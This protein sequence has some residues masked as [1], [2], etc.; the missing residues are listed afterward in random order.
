MPPALWL[1]LNLP[2]LALDALGPW[3][4]GV[5][6]PALVWQ[7]DAGGRTRTVLI[8]NAAAQAL[9]VQAGQRLGS[10]QALAP[11][12]L[13][14][15]R[16]PAREAALLERLAL[17]LGSLS[18][19][20]VIEPPDL[21]LD[22]HASLRLFG[23]LRPLLRRADRLVRA[24]AVQPRWSLASTPLAARLLAHAPPAQR[25]RR[26]VQLRSTRRRVLAL[27]LA[28]L[29]AWGLPCGATG[30][31]RR[32]ADGP[33]DAA[34]VAARRAAAAHI[35]TL[36]MLHALGARCLADLQ[37]LPRAG[38]RRRGAQDWVDAL[39]RALGDQP[40]PRRCHDPPEAFALALELPW[41][42]DA[43]P[44]IE[45]A[46]A[47]LVQALCGW[48]ALRWRAAQGLSLI[49]RHDY[50]SRRSLPDQVLRLDLA[51]PSREARHLQTLL[52][53]HLQHLVLAA[54]VDA[55]TL[56]LDTSLPEA[57]RPTTLWPDARQQA[58]AH[59]SLVDRLQARLG[60]AQVRR[61]LPQADARPEKAD[62]WVN[63]GTA[64]AKPLAPH[65]ASRDALPA[66]T[67]ALPR[68]TWLL[69][70]PLPL[71][72]HDGQ[73]LHQGRPLRILSRAERIETGW[74][75]G[76]LVRRDYH[77]ALGQAGTLCWI[78]RERGNPAFDDS[79]AQPRWF[80]H[81]LFG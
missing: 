34:G 13:V 32:A 52:R 76:A 35:A 77:V 45:A 49:L 28:L 37:R 44:A 57:G 39:D 60:A 4:P 16:D 14:L 81:G 1:C 18:P 26:C 51:T 40:D 46:A 11:Q 70:A 80:L 38:L 31:D 3:P 74:H 6:L 19:Q 24:Q 41:R 66:L 17:G 22:I 29:G 36:E 33:A 48:L 42:A 20:R 78:Y 30:T 59:T 64:D 5:S 10:A 25:Q 15:A 72:E 21:L 67:H 61:L 63:A 47:P 27:P 43:V 62:R 68:P 55:I 2:T 23:G 9:G 8:A 65:A 73:P 58:Q 69:P 75:D 71:A 7:A 53:E 56:Q 79:P 12:A 50:S 54:P